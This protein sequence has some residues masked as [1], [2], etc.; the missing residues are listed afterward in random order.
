[1]MP[2]GVEAGGEV[3][4]PAYA[5]MLDTA[6]RLKLGTLPLDLLD[7]QLETIRAF[8]PDTQRGWYPVT[9]IRLL[10]GREFPIDEAA[11][12]A[13]TRAVSSS[14]ASWISGRRGRCGRRSLQRP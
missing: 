8:D 7:E 13:A 10:P 1:M 3:M 11:R 6:R 2:G 14:P 12:Q 9:E 4:G 5:R